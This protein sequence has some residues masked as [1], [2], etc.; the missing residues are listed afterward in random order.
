MAHF[1]KLDSNNI[2]LNILVVD[3]GIT[4]PSGIEIE[5]LGINLLKDL[6]GQHTLWKQTSYNTNRGTHTHGKPQNRKNFAGIG[7]TYDVTRN[8]FIPL[9]PFPSWILDENTCSYE[10]PIKYPNDGKRYKWNEAT[11]TWIWISDR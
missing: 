10:A 8:A 4:T 3:N 1:A 2:V 9:K 5:Q 6:Y 11:Q 7:Y